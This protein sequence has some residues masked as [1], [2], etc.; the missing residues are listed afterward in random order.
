[1]G[2]VLTRLLSS[3]SRGEEQGEEEEEGAHRA[4][5][6]PF[7]RRRREEEE[8][9]E[10]RETCSPLWLLVKR[11]PDVWGEV[12]KSLNTTDMKFLYDVSKDSRAVIRR[13]GYVMRDT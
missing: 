11:Y 13:Q 3:I 7:F 10:A 12:L 5:G 6:E 9:E 2:Q 4:I 1:M 8:E